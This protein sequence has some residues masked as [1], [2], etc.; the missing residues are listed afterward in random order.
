MKKKIIII[1]AAVVLAAAAIVA[2]CNFFGGKDTPASYDE[3]ESGIIIPLIGNTLFVTD[4]T[5]DSLTVE[6]I[7][8][9]PVDENPPIAD[10]DDPDYVPV[11]NAET[12]KYIY[13][14]YSFEVK[15]DSG[16]LTIEYD[17]T[18][19]DNVSAEFSVKLEDKGVSEIKDLY[20]TCNGYTEKVW[21]R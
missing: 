12:V 13:K 21:E 1:I 9:T 16:Y 6:G 15:G 4:E 14:D 10:I 3:K 8:C 18:K 17:K 2:V 5:E 11:D 7:I 19:D 20:V